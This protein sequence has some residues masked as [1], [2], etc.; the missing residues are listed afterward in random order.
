MI[1]DEM[2]KQ[3]VAAI[4]ANRSKY[5]SDA[6][7]AIALGI[8][9]AQFSTI[10]KGK[11]DRVLSDTNWISIARRLD[12]Q[13][14]A[15]Q[16][17][18]T[19]KTPVYMYIYNQLKECQDNSQ[20]GL[21]CDRADVGKTYT[22]RCYVKENRNAVYIDCSQV[23]SKQKLIRQIAREYGI[24]HTGRYADVYEDLVYYLRTLENP[25][26]ILD[27][28]GDLD[29]AAFLELKAL[30]NATEFACGWYMMGA[31]GLKQKI[32]TNMGR[33]KV[34]YEELFSRFGKRFL[35]ITPDGKEAWDDFARA[36]VSLIARANCPDVDIKRIYHNTGGSLRRIPV[37]LSKL[38]KD[39][40]QVA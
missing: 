24:N 35:K 20:S 26:V 15:R 14:G 17:W 10:R 29:Y 9:A 34:G 23:K 28:A 21:L 39:I 1:T 27:E 40:K 7:F 38:V 36:Q 25:L 30:W 11:L 6:K 3:I 19:A 37:E 13:L 18:K 32:E 8:N 31:D 12:V 16:E 33:K 2:K 22:A 4:E 5:A